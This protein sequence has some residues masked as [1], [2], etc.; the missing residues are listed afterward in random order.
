MTRFDRRGLLR[1]SFA[2]GGGLVATPT[3]VAL[4]G[5]GPARAAAPRVEKRLAFRSIHTDEKVD[6]RFFGPSGFDADGLAEID[7][8][9]RDWRTNEVKA[10]DPALVMLLADLRDA[11]DV[12]PR[13]PFDIISGYRSPATNAALRARSGGVATRSQHMLG[14]ATDLA[15][16]GVPLDRV[17]QAALALARGGVGF[18]PSSGFVHVDTGRVRRW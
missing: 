8:G 1:A 10:I 9:L 14:K 7:H 13:R 15:L 17:R 2:L 11:L 4:A 5:A 18:Y 6:A 16:P 12:A 3:A